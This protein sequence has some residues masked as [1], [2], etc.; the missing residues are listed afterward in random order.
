[1]SYIANGS[2][3][4]RFFLTECFH[5]F[6]KWHSAED[7]TCRGN[8]GFLHG[9]LHLVRGAGL[10]IRP[11]IPIQ[12]AGSQGLSPKLLPMDVVDAEGLDLA[13]VGEDKTCG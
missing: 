3:A 6:P 1:M 8:I 5:T 13:K 10:A 2:L 7:F 11:D 4:F 12:R 9:L